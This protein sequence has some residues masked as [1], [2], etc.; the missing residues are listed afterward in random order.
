MSDSVAAPAPD[1]ARFE[2][3]LVENYALVGDVVAFIARRHHLRAGDAEEFGAI[4]NL[5]LVEDDY[6]ILRKFEGRCTLRTYL[7]VVLER[8]YLDWRTSLWGRW[9]PSA[10]ARHIGALGILLEQLLV[11][12]GY[13]YSE[14]CEIMHQKHGVRQ[15]DAEID[16][17]HE[18][19]PRR[20][21]RR[22]VDADEIEHP[23]A[24]SS[25]ADALVVQGELS[26]AVQAACAALDASLAE[27]NESDRLL[28]ELRFYENLTVPRIERATNRDHKW[29]Y[30]RLQT[31]L[32]DLQ[33]RLESRG[34]DRSLIAELIG[35]GDVDWDSA[36][37]AMRKTLRSV[38]PYA[39]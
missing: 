8:T 34:I 2:A 13:S 16:R 18:R 32:A 12:D 4:A 17:V 28:L 7:I 24:P 31:L 19:L 20:C 23:A 36:R 35:A 38:R 21:P 1:R 39:G 30:R 3:I 27:L 26:H 33:R 11:R 5:R 25:D 14:A 6:G 37:P 29:L 15:S 10:E 22:F 9:R